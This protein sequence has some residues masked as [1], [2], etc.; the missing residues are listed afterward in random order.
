MASIR[1]RKNKDG[2]IISYEIRV[3]KGYDSNGKQ[4]KPYTATYKPAPNMTAKQIEKELRRQE[5]QFEEQCR[6]GIA[7][8]GKQ[9]FEKY[10]EY[11]IAL[12][13]RSGVKH[14]V[15]TRYRELIKRINAGIGHIRLADV[16]PQHLN[17]L[18]EQLSQKGIRENNKKAECKVDLKQV[19]KE[20]GFTKDGVAKSAGVSVQTMTSCYKKLP[21]LF[22]N[23][24]K[25]AAA[26]NMPLKSLFIITV[27]DTPLSTKTVQEHHRLISVILTQAEK[28][29]LIPYNP[30]RKATPPKTDKTQPNYFQPEEVEQIRNALE[31]VNIKWK[32]LIHLLLITG[33]RRG[34]I[35]GLKWSAV[36]W[37]NNQIHIFCM[38]N[39]I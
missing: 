2:D 12:K 34:E 22:Q 5:V 32:T 9:T 20:S 25:I 10:A 4:L 29:M 38:N 36:D 16:R 14:S 7:G 21:I 19:L 11:V 18:Y 30:A 31:Q 23:A 13:E 33:G 3:H 24:E 8:D 15:I 1:P 28:E 39:Y 27:D 35:C 6:L 26:L 37:K 17:V